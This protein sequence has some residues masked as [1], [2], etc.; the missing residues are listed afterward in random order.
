MRLKYRAGKETRNSSGRV[1]CLIYAQIAHNVSLVLRMLSEQLSD[2]SDID[3]LEVTDPSH[4]PVRKTVRKER[5]RSRSPTPPPAV[6]IQ[7][8]QKAR[9]LVRYSLQHIVLPY[10]HAQLD[11]LWKQRL[12]LSHRIY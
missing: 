3:I 5:S 1:R 10:P 7:E 12:D 11:K 9:N 6:S 4:S 2:N 8:I